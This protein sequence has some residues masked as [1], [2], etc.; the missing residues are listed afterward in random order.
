MSSGSRG[1]QC[2]SCAIT[3]WKG[4]NR[5]GISDLLIGRFRLSLAK[6]YFHLGAP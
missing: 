6:D 4:V 2:N 1:S 3:V 5:F